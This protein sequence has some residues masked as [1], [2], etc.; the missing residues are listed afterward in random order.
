LIRVWHIRKKA[1]AHEF[2]S[3]NGAFYWGGRWTPKGYRVVYSGES[4]ALALLEILIRF[5]R[6]TAS[7]LQWVIGYADIPDYTIYTLPDK[8][9]PSDWRTYPYPPSTV[10]LGLSWLKTAKYVVLSV[11]STLEPTSR[12]Y[13]INVQHVD[14]NKIHFSSIQ[15]YPLDQRA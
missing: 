7:K 8:D 2:W 5:K 10:A 14:A 9:L 4:K 6:Q 3:G 13:L 11:P 12:K 15:D 1:Y